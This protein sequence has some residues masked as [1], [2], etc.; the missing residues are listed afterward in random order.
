MKNTYTMTDYL[1]YYLFKAYGKSYDLIGPPV[2]ILTS[3]AFMLVIETM[4]QNAGAGCLEVKD[5][6]IIR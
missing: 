5:L 1:I 3:I 6:K 2:S 4:L